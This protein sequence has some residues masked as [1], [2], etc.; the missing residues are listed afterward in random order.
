MLS[1]EECIG[2]SGLSEE[3]VA[4]IAE[5]EHVPAI[6]AAEM[7][8]ELLRTPK[9]IYRLHRMFLDN[10]EHAAH[11]GQREKAKYLDRT[12]SHFRAEHPMPRVL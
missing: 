4:V 11:A 12:Y 2:F 1:L 10:L 5:H 9:G 3:E 6:V 8:C 7:G